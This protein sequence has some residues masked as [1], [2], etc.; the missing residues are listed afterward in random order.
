MLNL[1]SNTQNLY[2]VMGYNSNET[3]MQSTN[4]FQEANLTEEELTALEDQFKILASFPF[5]IH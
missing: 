4:A 2:N 3:Q 5:P 1:N